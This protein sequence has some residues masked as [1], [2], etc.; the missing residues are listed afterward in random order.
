MK[1]WR[2]RREDRHAAQVDL[3]RARA[4]VA[5][6][7]RAE[8]L[9]ALQDVEHVAQ[10]LQHH[11]IGLGAHGGRARIESSCRSS[12]RTGRRTEFGDRIVVGQDRRAHRW[13]WSGRHVLLC[14]GVLARGRAMLL[15][16]C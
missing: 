7:L 16:A 10:H 1:S 2:E 4:V 15:R 5:F 3:E 6:E 13:G 12:R 14:G 11:A 8:R 9:V